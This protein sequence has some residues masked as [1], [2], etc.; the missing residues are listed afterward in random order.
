MEAFKESTTPLL[1]PHQIDAMQRESRSTEKML[2]APPHIQNR[3]E[4]RAEVVRRL[5]GVNSDLEKQ[6]PKAYESDILD[7]A[8]KRSELLKQEILEGMPTQAEMRRNPAG[9]VDKHMRWEKHN[10]QKIM[11]W[12]NIQLRLNAGGE[13]GE[14]E[15]ARDVANFERYRPA[16]GSQEINMHN[17]QIPG[18]TIHL[19]RPEDG[20]PA[21]MS[22]K[23]SAVLK[24]LNPELHAKMALLTNDQRHEILGMV[25]SYLDVPPDHPQ[26]VQPKPA[27]KAP[28]RKKA[29]KK[30]NLSPEERQRRSDRAKQMNVLNTRRRAA[31]HAEV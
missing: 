25:N 17:E 13:L 27:R 2:N 4:D 22:E 1:R 21:F 12:K 16:G 10:K 23:Q 18:K 20:L 14:I 31:E 29:A 5:K 19:P 24:E 15:F 28:R 9:A 30:M 11:E 6:S 7:S 8:V 26:P 3:L